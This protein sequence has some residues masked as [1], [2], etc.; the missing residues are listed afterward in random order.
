MNYWYGRQSLSTPG[1]D[2]VHSLCWWNG[3]ALVLIKSESVVRSVR[4]SGCSLFSVE[5][6][7][8]VLHPYVVK[9]FREI[10]SGM[11]A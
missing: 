3:F 5:V 10:F 6:C 8:T 2:L 11:C 1:I 4:N 9:S 7:E